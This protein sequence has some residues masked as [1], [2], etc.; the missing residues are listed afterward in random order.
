MSLHIA[1]KPKDIAPLVIITG[2]PL[3]AKEMSLFFLTK[4]Q[5]VSDVRGS[6]IYTGFYKGKMVSIATSGIG[7]PSISI[8][9]QELRQFYNVKVILRVGSCGSFVNSLSLGQIVNVQ[10]SYSNF[11]YYSDF[12][13]SHWAFPSKSLFDIIPKAGKEIE[14]NSISCVNAV[15]EPEFYIEAPGK[16]FAQQNVLLWDVVEMETYSLFVNAKKL[17]FA[18]ASLLVVTD[19]LRFAGSNNYVVQAKMT[20]K[21]RVEVFHP[22]F[23]LALR[24]LLRWES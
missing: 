7:H 18:A 3:R 10:K 19:Q 2:D 24:V 12:Y 17:H 9:V 8:Y 4:P 21:Q 20:V 16:T 5:L 1:A 15:A 23:A 6:F 11:L 22:V 14:L 13:A